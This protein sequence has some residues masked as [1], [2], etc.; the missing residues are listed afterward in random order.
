MPAFNP[1]SFLTGLRFLSK[2]AIEIL[3]DSLSFDKNP[4]AYTKKTQEGGDD[5]FQMEVPPATLGVSPPKKVL[6]ET[7]D[8]AQEITGKGIH[9][10]RDKSESFGLSLLELHS[11]P[12]GEKAYLNLGGV[13]EGRI[14]P[15]KRDVVDPE[16]GMQTKVAAGWGNYEF[17]QSEAKKGFN[18]VIKQNKKDLNIEFNKKKEDRDKYKITALKEMNKYLKKWDETRTFTTDKETG[19]KFRKRDNDPSNWYFTKGG[20]IPKDEFAN[21]VNSPIFKNLV[22]EKKQFLFSDPMADWAPF[23][24]ESPKKPWRLIDE[25]EGYDIYTGRWGKKDKKGKIKGPTRE[26]QLLRVQKALRSPYKT[27]AQVSDTEA[28]SIFKDKITKPV[29]EEIHETLINKNLPLTRENYEDVLLNLLIREKDKG[30]TPRTEAERQE[31]INII[32]NVGFEPYPEYMPGAITWD[33]RQQIPLRQLRS[34]ESMKPETGTM[35][36]LQTVVLDDILEGGLPRKVFDNLPEEEKRIVAFATE[37]YKTVQQEIR[38]KLNKLHGAGRKIDEEQ[39]NDLVAKQTLE[40]LNIFVDKTMRDTSKA[41]DEEVGEI[42]KLAESP[43]RWAGRPETKPIEPHE[44]LRDQV[45]LDI[46]GLKKVN[47]A[48]GGPIP[49]ILQNKNKAKTVKKGLGVGAA[50]RGWGAVR[51]G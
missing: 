45:Q 5:F 29:A 42:E 15:A 23:L 48:K 18:A 30:I 39:L 3:D 13:G 17:N 32:G 37:K 34:D 36:A 51:T 46:K 25:D 9:T 7:R 47:K 38:N 33:K 16:T 2:E 19:R 44:L 49:K 21:F 11:D 24:T 4:S 31:L 10:P 50:L 41:L 6:R 12:S 35:Q 27:I 20:F 26:E 1:K 22:K 43:L 40:E 8:I 28:Q 14:G